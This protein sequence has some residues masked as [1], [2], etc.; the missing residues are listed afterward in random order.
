MFTSVFFRNE[1][2]K[3]VAL[4]NDFEKKWLLSIFWWCKKTWKMMIHRFIPACR[5]LAAGL[6]V[7]D[8]SRAQ[9]QGACEAGVQTS[10][11]VPKKSGRTHDKNAPPIC[12]RSISLLVIFESNVSF[13]T[14][15]GGL[16]E[17]SHIS[18]T[19]KHSLYSERLLYVTQIYAQ[20]CFFDGTEACF[21][22]NRSFL[23]SHNTFWESPAF[24]QWTNIS[25]F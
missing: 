22:R 7:L 14:V 12:G 1:G 24:V 21:W 15:F 19:W 2:L 10:L 13:E 4:G 16:W 17:H 25:A 3:V 11:G 5:P 9:P 18:D 6:L 8:V 23:L 20:L